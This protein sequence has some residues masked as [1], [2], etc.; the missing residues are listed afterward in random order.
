MFFFFFNNENRIGFKR[1]TEADLGFSDTSHQSHIGLYEGVLEFLDDSD[2]VK[3]AMLIYE[4]YCDVLD[5]SFDRIKNPDGSYR[6]PKIRIGQ[7]PNISVV[8]KIR[9]FAREHPNDDWYLAWMGLESKELVFWLIKNNT[10]DYATARKFFSKDKMVLDEVSATYNEAK[11]YLLNRINFVSI[12]VQ[13]DIEVSSLT[14]NV[15]NKY[16]TID[17]ENAER[18]Y[19][20]T[21]KDGEAL[22]AE[23]LEKEKAANRINSFVWENKSSESGLPFD[24]IINEN[25]FIDVKSTRFDFNQY[26]FYSNQE[27]EFAA[28]HDKSSYAVYRVF[29]MNVEHKKFVICNNCQ[30]YMNS[31]QRPIIDFKN[32]I[33]TEQALMHSIK[34]GIK[35]SVCFNDISQPILL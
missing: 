23:F 30:V 32:A 34:L 3:S 7:D 5:C 9:E 25:L 6:S 1:L 10:A 24:F 4:N 14:G 15:K 26:L 22:I 31:I 19:K 18:Q 13:K 35:P 11:N 27:I 12:N 16:R 17:L 2:V 8:S 29:D 33:R 21:G 28:S 20:Q